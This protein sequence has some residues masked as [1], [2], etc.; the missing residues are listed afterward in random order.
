MVEI[1]TTFLV[2]SLV[3]V[4]GGPLVVRLSRPH[5]WSSRPSSDLASLPVP[6]SCA[7][8]T[9][10]DLGPDP[11]QWPSE[12]PWPNTALNELPWPSQTWDDPHFGTKAQELAAARS[13]HAAHAE[14]HAQ[15][16][17]VQTPQAE[18]AEHASSQHAGNRRAR[19]EM[20]GLRN[21]AHDMKAEMARARRDALQE[22]VADAQRVMQARLESSQAHAGAK[23][24]RSQP[25]DATPGEVVSVRDVPNPQELE[26][27]V[28]DVGL[29]GAVQEVMT[30]T[31]WDFRTAAQYLAKARRSR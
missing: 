14:S 26:R 4:I 29:S 11:M 10:M 2:A 6:E 8:F 22:Q 25:R 5:L 1:V 23:T 18:A 13:A 28:T 15:A 19:Q 7:G 3:A 17:S 24:T 30:R 20:V 27:L 21:R 12:T 9:P 31:G 16:V